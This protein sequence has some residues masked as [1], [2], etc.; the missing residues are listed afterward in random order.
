MSLKYVNIPLKVFLNNKLIEKFRSQFYL[1]HLSGLFF[2]SK[3]QKQ[4]LI[5]PD[6]KK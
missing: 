4:I 1:L 2:P 3:N 5:T 6:I